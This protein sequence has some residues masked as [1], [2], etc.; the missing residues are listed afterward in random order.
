MK[1]RS[2]ADDRDHRRPRGDQRPH[3]GIVLGL[4]AAPPR[5]AE[6]ADLRVLQ[7][8]IPHALKKLR[9]LFVRQRIAPFDEIEA[10]AVQPLGDQQLVLQR[11]ADPFALA[12]VAK[13]GVVDL[14][15][16]HNVKRL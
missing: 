9:V 10:E 12:A 2:L 1:D 7:V 5:H 11:K 8:E 13:R 15:P 14:N 6:G 16:A 3:A 4:D